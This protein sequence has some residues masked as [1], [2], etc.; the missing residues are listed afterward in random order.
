MSARPDV[1]FTSASFLGYRHSPDELGAWARLTTAKPAALYED[2]A[3]RA[4]ATAI[5]AA[6]GRPA[7]VVHRSTLHALNDVLG[8]LPQPGDLVIIDEFAYPTTYSAA[9]GAAAKGAEVKRYPH[10]DPPEPPARARSRRP[11]RLFL[12]SDGW[13]PGCNRPAPLARLQ[14]LAA[15]RGGVLVVDDTLACGVLGRRTHGLLGDGTGTVRWAGLEHHRVL[16]V[17]S[18]AKALSSPICVTTGDRATIRRLGDGGSRWHSSPPSAPDLRAALHALADP[19][20]A[21][22]RAR[23]AR[24]VTEVRRGLRWAGFEVVGLPF[25]QVS[26]RT[27]NVGTALAWHHALGSRGLVTFVQRARCRPESVLGVLI[28]SDHLPA[29]L[30][31][32][33]EELTAVAAARGRR[34]QGVAV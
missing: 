14:R 26:I 16:W 32:L 29:D 1:D 7:G 2:P 18:L 3:A 4:V 25:P 33:V 21:E 30:D 10:H 22:R 34:P 19:H 8:E 31:R 11:S 9:L 5:A 23:L 12:V 13:C 17:A 20:A 27:P 24:R 28:R 6:Q 15:D